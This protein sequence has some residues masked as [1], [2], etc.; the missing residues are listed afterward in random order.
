MNAALIDAE[1]LIAFYAK[2]DRHHQQVKNFL[3]DSLDFFMMS[4]EETIH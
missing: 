4:V 2:S 1:P 3:M